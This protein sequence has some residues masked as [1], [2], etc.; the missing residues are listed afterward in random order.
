[1]SGSIKKML[2]DDLNR[3]KINREKINWII[4]NLDEMFDSED[5]NENDTY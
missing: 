3:E 1:M 2:T 5:E 4:E